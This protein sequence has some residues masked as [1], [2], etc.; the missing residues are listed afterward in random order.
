MRGL[1]YHLTRF[2]NYSAALA[3]GIAGVTLFAA[4]CFLLVLQFG[5]A[6]VVLRVFC[7]YNGLH[8]ILGVL[9]GIK[10]AAN[11]AFPIFNVAFGSAGCLNSGVVNKFVF[12][13]RKHNG[14][15]RCCKLGERC[16]PFAFA[17]RFAGSRFNYAVNSVNGF[18][19]S[20]VRVLCAGMGC[21]YG[22]VVSAPNISG[23]AP[24]VT[25][26][27]YFNGNFR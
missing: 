14:F 6:D 16:S 23:F 25:L 2:K 7:G 10:L 27:A 11:G 18:G 4:G 15:F 24:L 12:K 1:G 8:L 19:F 5:F 20:L 26:L 22:L 21:S 3:N 17:R 9:I 13:R